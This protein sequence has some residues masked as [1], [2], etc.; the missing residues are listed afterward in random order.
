MS[1]ATP[2]YERVQGVKGTQLRCL[3]D[4]ACVYRTR[5]WSAADGSAQEE[6][7]R[8]KWSVHEPETEA[9]K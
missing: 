9:R 3:I 1:E 6:F 2:L 4:P 5:V 7:Y 8:H